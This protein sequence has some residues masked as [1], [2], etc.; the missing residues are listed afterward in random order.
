MKDMIIT[1]GRQYGSGGREI[2][3][4]LA[5][6]LNIPCYDTLLLEKTVQDSG[7]SK[8]AV[9]KYDEQMADKWVHRNGNAGGP[10]QLPVSMQ[11]ALLSLKQ[12][13]KLRIKAQQ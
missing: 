8:E 10:D 2:G 3:E 9:D 12:S 1:I 7:L 4:K 11:S 5:K 6:E 13:M